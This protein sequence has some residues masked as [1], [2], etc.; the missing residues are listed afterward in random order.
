MSDEPDTNPDLSAPDLDAIQAGQ[1]GMVH[2]EETV[3]PDGEP[4]TPPPAKAE[5][6]PAV[7]ATRRSTHPPA[8]IPPEKRSVG[9]IPLDQIEA[10]ADLP[11]D[12][13]VKLATLAR[14]EQ[15]GTDEEVSG[16]GIA[17]VLKGTTAVCATIVDAPAHRPTPPGLVPTRGTLSDPVALRVVAQDGDASVAVWDP[18]VVEE[19]LETCPWVLDELVE[20]SDRIQAQA[21]ATMGPVGDLDENSRSQVLS[22]LQVRALAE[23]ELFLEAGKGSCG[24]TV[25]GAGE[26]QAGDETLGAG[27]LLFASSAF[28]GSP[29]SADAKAGQGGALLLVGDRKAA[30]ELFAVMPQLIELFASV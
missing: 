25:I 26:V 24:I 2:D 10:F 5:E 18:N 15:L 28:T 12:Q 8:T 29:P 30:Q 17:L 11:G 3:V 20:L 22:R 27:D 4:E 7:P 16:F 9:G 6:P 19:A 21:G 13:Q 1:A 23:G 14:V